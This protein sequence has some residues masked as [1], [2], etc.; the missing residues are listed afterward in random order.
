ME[1]SQRLKELRKIKKLTIDDL[2]KA[3]GI[4][5]ATISQ[6]ENG[7]YKP[8]ADAIISLSNVLGVSADYFLLGRENETNTGYEKGKDNSL[9]R[10]VVD[11]LS[12]K[13][14]AVAPEL[15]KTLVLLVTETITS[16]K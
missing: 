6:L 5:S 3:S 1:I 7:K 4:S 2:A 11:E 9:E 10:I 16:K 14:V 12:T 13:D 15:L 8:S